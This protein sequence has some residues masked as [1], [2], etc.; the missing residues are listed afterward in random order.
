MRKGGKEK[1]DEEA[2]EK[3]RR[4]G[5]GRTQWTQSDTPESTAQ[6]AVVARSPAHSTDL[7]EAT[8]PIGRSGCLGGGE[9]SGL[10]R[11][12]DQ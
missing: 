3:F 8:R 10:A 5:P 7:G 1:E 11:L 12:T 4:N 2:D 9:Y 6:A